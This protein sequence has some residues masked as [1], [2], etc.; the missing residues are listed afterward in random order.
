MKLAFR[1][2]VAYVGD[3]AMN[4]V[5]PHLLDDGYLASRAS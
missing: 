5:T 3:A 2:V 4:E 1:D